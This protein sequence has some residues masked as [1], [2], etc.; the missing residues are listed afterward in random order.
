MMFM[1]SPGIVLF[2]ALFHLAFDWI[3]FIR[4][5]IRYG[6]T[7]KW[8]QF[9]YRDCKDEKAS[10]L[11]VELDI[12]QKSEKEFYLVNGIQITQCTIKEKVK[13][14][15]PTSYMVFAAKTSWNCSLCM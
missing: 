6:L 7:A 12:H 13:H 9:R 2:F 14:L 4:V 10:S 8:T 1:M 15:R 11:K 3:G 5:M